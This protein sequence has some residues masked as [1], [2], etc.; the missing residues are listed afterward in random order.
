[1]INISFANGFKIK[2]SF[3][4]STT[5]GDVISVLRS[6]NP[7]SFSLT[8]DDQILPRF[9]NLRFAPINENACFKL[10]ERKAQLFISVPSYVYKVFVVEIELSKSLGDLK[11]R[12]V[13]HLNIPYYIPLKQQTIMLNSTPL[14]ENVR[15]LSSFGI[16]NHSILLYYFNI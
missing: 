16:Q 2:K 8:I 3:R 13:E 7:E 1:M 6:K 4:P 10:I 5:V 12:I 9:L 15:S 11:R 14:V